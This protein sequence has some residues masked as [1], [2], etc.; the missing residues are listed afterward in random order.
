MGGEGDVVWDYPDF[1][2]VG[3]LDVPYIPR[4]VA[5]LRIANQTFAG[6]FDWIL[7]GDDETI[8]FT[9]RIG[10]L[11]ATLDPSVPYYI[12][13][14]FMGS[15]SRFAK[16]GERIFN[17]NE[18]FTY[19]LLP[20]A[21]PA[22]DEGRPDCPRDS[23]AAPCTPA[24]ALQSHLC[25]GQA[26]MRSDSRCPV[27]EDP[28]GFSSSTCLNSTHWIHDDTASHFAAGNPGML[29]S[30]GFMESVSA[31]RFRLC[32]RRQESYGDVAVGNCLWGFGLAPTNP[33]D[34]PGEPRFS[35]CM[36]GRFDTAAMGALMGE[37]ERSGTCGSVDPPAPRQLPLPVDRPR[38]FPDAPAMFN[39]AT[40][41]L[42]H[43]T[44]GDREPVAT[45]EVLRRGRK[46]VHEFWAN[47]TRFVEFAKRECGLAWNGAGVS[48][49]DGARL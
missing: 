45:E 29:I 14:S 13:D 40:T 44:L 20:S 43:A 33:S 23:P 1:P 25:R 6:T 21:E 27:R 10:A 41:Y 5:A 49:R 18:H 28:F 35:R 38:L 42:E 9:D 4:A 46:A 3:N 15:C 8:F 17:M 37:L 31:D 47:R 7:Y 32:E 26:V 24:A 36:F 30:R 2:A 48:G 22:P 12:S 16:E 39:A 19:C 11:V 34:V